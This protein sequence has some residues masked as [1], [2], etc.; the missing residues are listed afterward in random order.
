MTKKADTSDAPAA[1]MAPDIL[2]LNPLQGL[3]VG[4][5]VHYWPN[6]QQERACSPGPWA[7]IITDI[8]KPLEG[9]ETPHGVVTLNVQMPKPAPIGEDPVARFQLVP[10]SEDRARGTWSWPAR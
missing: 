2:I 3:A 9:E 1:E 10:F 6:E 5:V 7:A 8:H 4:R